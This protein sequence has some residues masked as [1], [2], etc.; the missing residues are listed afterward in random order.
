MENNQG[1]LVRA[2]R[3]QLGR[4]IRAGGA[5]SLWMRFCQSSLPISVKVWWTQGLALPAHL[6]KL[7]SVIEAEL[8]ISAAQLQSW[9]CPTQSCWAFSLHRA[10]HSLRPCGP[11][12]LPCSPKHLRVFIVAITQGALKWQRNKVR[13]LV[14]AL[15]WEMRGVLPGLWCFY[16]SLQ[17][18]CRKTAA[19]WR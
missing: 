8:S 13:R 4:P 6:E 9:H 18:F 19:V 14:P 7:C 10:R 1:H 15:C 16:G 2:Q 5:R 12:E 17:L 11:G 3:G